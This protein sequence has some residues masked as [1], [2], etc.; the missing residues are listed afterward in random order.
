M[1]ILDFD[2]PAGLVAKV[3]GSVL[4]AFPLPYA[5][6]CGLKRFFN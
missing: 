2:P 3:Q 4:H 1:L 6:S 5:G